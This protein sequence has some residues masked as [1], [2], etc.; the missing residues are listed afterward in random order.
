MIQDGEREGDGVM[1]DGR[2]EDGEHHLVIWRWEPI[3]WSVWRQC[4]IRA[5]SVAGH[6][7][8]TSLSFMELTSHRKLFEG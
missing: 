5:S 4:C 6:S 1:C 2:L 7:L 8:P 3:H